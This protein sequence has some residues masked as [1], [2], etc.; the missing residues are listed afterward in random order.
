YKDAIYMTYAM[1]QYYP[2]NPYLEK[3]MARA[4]YG[5]VL[6]KNM[7]FD[8]G[9]LAELF[10][11]ILI[12]S[13]GDNTEEKPTGEIGRFKR[14]ASK[15][16]SEAWNVLALQYVWNVHTKYAADNDIKTWATS[17]FREIT[18]FHE[19]KQTDFQTNDSLYIKLGEIAA[20]DTTLKKKAKS[21]SARDRFQLAVDSYDIDSIYT[22]VHYWSF[23]FIDELKDPK[24]V[25]M[26]KSATQ[27]ADSVKQVN[28][29]LDQM[30]SAESRRYRRRRKSELLGS[31]GIQRIVLIDPKYMVYDQRNE[32][33]PL[34]VSATLEGREQFVNELKRSAGLCNI[35]LTLLDQSVLDTSSAAVFN[36]L[37]TANRWLTVRD[38]VRASKAMPYS[39]AEMQAMAQKY[40]TN[41]FMWTAYIV[42]R[43]KRSFT[44]VRAISLIL[45]PIAPH[46]AY[47]L[48]SRSESVT[49]IAIVYDVSTGKLVYSNSSEMTNQRN[50]KSRMR[51]N[52][53]DLMR[54]ISNPKK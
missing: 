25:S 41:Y 39:Q 31:Q 17:L 46:T 28:E 13:T 50:T 54:Q 27:Y 37:N 7:L 53:Y 19:M 12:F 15:T 2:G 38:D 29:L 5:S 9:N 35:N 43:S 24:F 32:R 1:L 44:A 30:S 10:Q 33:V 23:A 14:V 18:F 4:L 22:N 6:D 21:N 42:E 8:F 51:L 3:E 11:N 16:Q 48:A 36:D 45:L 47:R 40:G 52:V 49:F 34:D 26:F 20:A